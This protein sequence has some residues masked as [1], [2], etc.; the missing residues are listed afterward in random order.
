LSIKT[1]FPRH[2]PNPIEADSLAKELGGYLSL[3]NVD[4]KV[5]SSVASPHNASKGSLVFCNKI[6][7]EQIQEVI[8]ETC[9]SVIIVS[10]SIKNVTNKGLI[11][12]DDPLEWFIKALN[13]LLDPTPVNSIDSMAKIS[14]DVLI[15]KGCSVGSGSVIQ[16]GCVIGN[17]CNIGVNCFIGP[18]TIVGDNVF[19]QNNTSIGGVGLGYHQSKS[20][21]TLFFPHIGLVILGNDVVVGSGCVIV[22]GELQD[23][24]ISDRTRIGNMVNIGHNVTIGEDC[25]ISSSTCITGGVIIENNCN[26]AAGVV[27]NTKI[28]IGSNCQI[29]LGSVVTKSIPSG[30]CVFGNPAKSLPTMRN[31]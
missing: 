10:K 28:V 9:A 2:I 17:N 14:S 27:V 23:T 24:I 22:R 7:I 3:L 15:G 8:N 1:S 11:V 13:F 19:I 26:I 5:I 4:K 18:N 31:F 20:E 16:D 6:S 30:V 21:T 12:V 29:G 25:V